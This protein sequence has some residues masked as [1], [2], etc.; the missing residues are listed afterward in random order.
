MCYWTCFT[1]LCVYVVGVR[2]C[3]MAQSYVSSMNRILFFSG[4]TESANDDFS[5]SVCE[6][7]CVVV[8]CVCV[9]MCVC[10]V[11]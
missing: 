1:I 3:T 6:C 7:V 11:L 5:V 10:G 4:F 8:V 2:L 9:R